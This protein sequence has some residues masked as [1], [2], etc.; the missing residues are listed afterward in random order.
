MADVCSINQNNV[1]LSSLEKFCGTDVAQFL[2][3]FSKAFVSNPQE[4]VLEPRDK[5]KTWYKKEFKKELDINNM[6]AVQVKNAIVKYYEYLVPTYKATEVQINHSRAAMFGYTSP[7]ARKKALAYVSMLIYKDYMNIER[8]EE[9]ITDNILGKLASEN[10]KYIRMKLAAML[11]NGD[12]ETYKAIWR[13]L[14]TNCGEYLDE[15]IALAKEDEPYDDATLNWTALYRELTSTYKENPTDKSEQSKVFDEIKNSKLITSLQLSRYDN[16]DDLEDAITNALNATEN[17]DHNDPDEADQEG[18]TDTTIRDYNLHHGELDDFKKHLTERIRRVLNTIPKLNSPVAK[19]NNESDKIQTNDQDELDLKIDPSIGFPEYHNATEIATLLYVYVDKD[20][21]EAMAQSVRIIAE[22]FPEYAGLSVLANQLES[23]RDL[24]YAFY[25]NFGKHII[26]KAQTVLN[27]GIVRYR[28]SNPNASRLDTLRAQYKNEFVSSCINVNYNDVKSDFDKLLFLNNRHKQVGVLAG[29]ENEVGRS[30]KV[31]RA[32]KALYDQLKLFYPSLSH[33]SLVN[34]VYNNP[35]V[36]IQEAINALYSDLKNAVDSAE[37]IQLAIKAKQDA[38]K[39]ATEH[40]ITQM[41]KIRTKKMKAEDATFKDVVALKKKDP[42]EAR[43]LKSPMAFAE[44][45]MKFTLIKANINSVNVHGNQSSDVLNSSL[46]TRLKAIFENPE[47]GKDS[48]LQLLADDYHLNDTVQYRMSNILIEQD[49]HPGIFRVVNGKYIPT[50]YANDLLQFTLFNGAINQDTET[51]V[52]Y[53]EMSKG[54]YIGTS[55]SNFFS[56]IDSSIDGQ[57]IKLGRYFL[58]IPSD[59]PK[60]FI[61]R[62]PRYLVNQEHPLFSTGN[63][64]EFDDFIDNVVKKITENNANVPQELL[65]A[66]E[67][68]TVDV[69]DDKEF[70]KH[71]SS[72]GETTVAIDD[73]LGVNRNG[74]EEGRKDANTIKLVKIQQ[75]VQKQIQDAVKDST[76]KEKDSKNARVAVIFRKKNN[77]GTYITYVLEGRYYNGKLY[78]TKF[79]NTFN[80]SGEKVNGEYQDLAKNLYDT[81]HRALEIDFIEKNKA[82][83]GDLSVT[84]KRVVNKDHQLFKQLKSV[85]KQ[86]L[87]DAVDAI[88]LMF[89]TQAAVDGNGQPIM[90]NGKQVLVITRDKKLRPILKEEWAKDTNGLS[91]IYH[92]SKKGEVLKENGKLAGRVFESDRF[93]VF[94]E[95]NNVIRNYGQEL[96]DT[97]LTYMTT[98]SNPSL[99]NLV[100]WVE[101]NGKFDLNLTDNQERA[102]E[103]KIEEFI[104]DFID[105]SY[106]RLKNKE[107]FLR[108]KT[109]NFDNVAD[110]M[111]NH[112]LMYVNSNELL[113][114]DTKYYEDVQTFLKRTKEYQASGNPYGITSIR[115]TLTTSPVDKIQIGPA[116]W[117]VELSDRFNAITFHTTRKFREQVLSSLE[118]A[119]TNKKLMGIHAMSEKD[120]RNLMRGND[121]KHGYTDA[122]VNDAQSYITFEEWIRRVAA[123]GELDKYTPLINRIM[124]GEELTPGDI[125][126]FVQV[127]KNIYYDLYYDPVTNRKIPRQIKNAEFVLVPQFIEGTELE[128]VYDFMR[129]N[130]IHQINTDE[131][132]K[133]ANGYIVDIFD[134]DGSLKQEIVDFNQVDSLERQKKEAGKNKDT[135]TKKVL[136]KQIKNA[137]KYKELI[138][139]AV[140]PYSYNYL[141]EQQ[142]V[143]QHMFAN[144]KFAIQIAKKIIDNIQRD[145]PLYATKQKYFDLMTANIKGSFINLMKD[146]NIPVDDNGN[147]ITDNPAAFENVDYEKFYEKL[148]VELGRLGLDDNALDYATLTGN[149]YNPSETVMPNYIGM[150]INK[151]ESIVQSVVTKAV[152]RQTLHGFHAA[153]ITN[154]G[155]VELASGKE[156]IKYDSSLKY[157]EEGYYNPTTNKYLTTEEYNKLSDK[158]GFEKATLPYVEV[159][160]PY[161]AFGIDKNS[162]HYK[163]MTDDEIIAEL[164]EK[165]L[166][167]FIGYRIP[168]EGKQ[169]IG[170][171]KLAKFIPDELGSTIV[172]PIE[173]VPQTGSDFDVDSVYGIMHKVTINNKGEVTKIKYLDKGDFDRY[174]W[175]DYIRKQGADKVDGVTKALYEETKSE[176]KQAGKSAVRA[177]RQKLQE[178]EQEAYKNLPGKY[179]FKDGK[180]VYMGPKG[181]VVQIHR[182]MDENYGKTPS[183]EKYMDQLANEIDL[184]ENHIKRDTFTQEQ[185]DGIDKYLEIVKLIYAGISQNTEEEAKIYQEARNSKFESTINEIKESQFKAYQEEAENEGLISYDE[186]I[187]KANA[188]PISY[189]TRAARDNEIVTCMIDIMGHPYSLEETLSR[190]NFDNIAGIPGVSSVDNLRSENE[191]KRRKNRSPFNILDEADF[192]E[193]AMQGFALK[194]FSVSRDTFCSVCNTV[195][196]TIDNVYAPIVAY[197]FSNL[198]DEEFTAKLKELHN[199]FDDEGQENVWNRG[200]VIAVRHNKI[201]WSNGNAISSKGERFS[202]DRNI[203]GKTITVYSSQTTAHIL[204]AMKSGPVPNVNKYTFGVYKTLVDVG[205]RYDTAIGFIMHPAVAVINEHYD[206]TNSI[207]ATDTNTKYIDLALN[208]YCDKLAKLESRLKFKKRATLDE[209]LA[210]I[211]KL[212]HTSYSTDYMANPLFA[213]DEE[214]I[215]LRIKDEKAYIEKAGGEIGMCLK[216]MEHVLHF[217]KLEKLTEN[218]NSVQQVTNPDKF[219]AK[220]SIFETERV[221][222]QI[223]DYVKSKWVYDG[224]NKIWVNRS[225]L[226]VDGRDILEAIYPDFVNVEKAY[227]DSFTDD[228]TNFV[229]S[230]TNVSRSKYPTLCSHLKYGSAT[231][232]IV[233]SMFFVTQTPQFKELINSLEAS[234]S[235][236]K[237]LDEKTYREARSYL[238]NSLYKYCRFLN[239]PLNYVKGKGFQFKEESRERNDQEVARVYGYSRTIDFFVPVE[240]KVTV[241]NEGREHVREISKKVVIEDVNNPTKKQI[242]M[243]ALLSPA[244]KIDFIKSRFRTIG[245]EDTIFNY[246]STRLYTTIDTRNTSAGAQTISFVESSA[247]IDYLRDLFFKAY[248][249]TNP[250]IALTA[251]DMIKYAFIVDGYMFTRNGISKLIPNSLLLNDGPFAGTNIIPEMNEKMSLINVYLDDTDI[252]NFIRANRNLRQINTRRVKK[253]KGEYEL[254]RRKEGMIFITP[255]DKELA[256]TYGVVDDNGLPNSYVRLKFEDRPVLYKIWTFDDGY[257][258]LTPLNDLEKNE[259]SNWSANSDNNVYPGKIGDYDYYASIIDEFKNSRNPDQKGFSVADF[260]RIIEKTNSNEFKGISYT[261]L[262]EKPTREFSVK[263]DTP[264][265]QTLINRA[266]EIVNDSNKPYRFFYTLGLDS[267][268]DKSAVLHIAIPIKH[269][270]RGNVSLDGARVF[271]IRPVYIDKL[272]KYFVKP[273]LDRSSLNEEE[274]D[275][276]DSLEKEMHVR[277]I[278]PKFAH[279]FKIEEKTTNLDNKEVK[280]IKF[281]TIGQKVAPI[282]DAGMAVVKGVNYIGTVTG[283]EEAAALSRNFKQQNIFAKA[284]V[285]ESKVEDIIIPA[286]KTLEKTVQNL[287]YKLKHFMPKEDG[288]NEYLAITDPEVIK[289]IKKDASWREKYLKAIMDPGAIESQFSIFRDLNVESESELLR[290]YLQKIKDSVKRLRDNTMVAEAQKNYV[291]DVLDK[292]SNRPDIKNGIVHVIDGYF[293]QSTLN[294]MFN[295]IQESPSALVQVTMKMIQDNLRATEIQTQRDLENFVKHVEDIKRRAAAAG[296]SINYDNIID[297]YGRFKRHYKQKLIDDRNKLQHNVDEKR[298][299]WIAVRDSKPNN[300]LS[301]ESIE[302]YLDYQRANLEYEEWKAKY[303]EQP[304]YNEHNNKAGI[305]DDGYYNTRNKLNRIMLDNKDSKYIFAVYNILRDKRARLMRRQLPDV[306][307]LEL[308]NEINELRDKIK[309]LQENQIFD[310]VTKTFI[311]KKNYGGAV[312]DAAEMVRRVWNDATASEILK[313]YVKNFSQN[314]FKYWK[315]DP[316]ASFDQQVKD[317]LA[318]VKKYE[319]PDEDGIPTVSQDKLAH[320]EDYQKA[321]RWLRRNARPIYVEEGDDSWIHEYA[322]AMAELHNTTEGIGVDYHIVYQNQKYRDENGD[323]DGIEISKDAELVDKIRKSQQITYNVFRENDFSDRTLMSLA[324][325]DDLIYTEAFWNELSNGKKSVKEEYKNTITAINNL[326]SPYYNERINAID[327]SKL[328]E[329]NTPEEV[330]NILTALDGLYTILDNLSKGTS[331]GKETAEFIEANCVTSINEARYSDDMTFS[332]TLPNNETANLFRKIITGHHKDDTP[333]NSYLYKSFGIKHADVFRQLASFKDKESQEYK[334]FVE[335]NKTIINMYGKYVDLNKTRARRIIKQY[336]YKT[337]TKYYKIAKDEALMEAQRIADAGGRSKEAVKRGKEYY[338]NWFFRNHVYNP[339]ERR[340]EPIAIWRKNAINNI[341]NSDISAE[342][343][344]GYDQQNRVVR[345]GYMTIG[346]A[347]KIAEVYKIPGARVGNYMTMQAKEF[348][349][350]YNED[351]NQVNKNYKEG[352]GHGENYKVGTSDEYD[353]PD[354][355]NEYEK[356]LAE[357]FQRIINALT[358]DEASQHYIQYGWL[359]SRMKREEN[360]TKFVG[361]ELKT[362]AGLSA[363]DNGRDDVTPVVDYAHDK[364]VPTPMLALVTKLKQQNKLKKPIREEFETEE[365]Y[366]EKKREWDAEEARIKA[367]D[368]EAHKMYHDRDYEGVMKE[369]ITRATRHNTIQHNKMNFYMAQ[370]LLSQYGAYRQRYGKEGSFKKDGAYSDAEQAEYMKQIDEDMLKQFTVTI[371]RFVNN[372]WKSPEGSLTRY[373][374]LLQAMTSAKFMILNH[375]GGIAN[376][377]YGEASI[378]SESKAAEFFEE[379]HSIKALGDYKN[380]IIDNFAHMYVDYSSTKEGAIIK[381]MNIVDYDEITGLTHITGDLAMISKKL[382]DFA[383]SAQTMGEHAMQNRVMF[384][385]MRS[386]RIFYNS[387]GTTDRHKEFGQPKYKFMTLKQYTEGKEEEA[388][389]EVL[390]PAQIEEYKKFKE[391]M[392]ADANKYKDF[393]WYRDDFVWAYARRLSW[394]KQSEFRKLKKEK[395]KKAR[396]E[397]EDDV[398]HPTILSQLK[399]GDNGKLAFIDGSLLAEMDKMVDGHENTSEEVLLGKPSDAI[400]FLGEFKGRVISVNKKIHG[401]YDKSGRAKVENNWYGSVL[402]QYHKHLPIGLSKRYRSK[403]YFNEER[404]A[405]EKGSYVSLLD[406]VSI[407]FKTNQ[408]KLALGDKEVEALKGV[409]NIIKSYLDFV[410]HMRTAIGVMPEYDKANIRR[411]LADFEAM[412]SALAACVALKMVASDDDRNRWWYNF[413]FYQTDRLASESAQY[414]PW[415]LPTELKKFYSNPIAG[416][417]EVDDITNTASAITQVI[418]GGMGLSDFDPVYD[419]GPNA[420]RYKMAV[421]IERNIP[422]WRGIRSAYIDINDNNKAYKAGKNVLGFFDTDILAE[423]GKRALK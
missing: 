126:E 330:Y 406:F 375:K 155:Y 107:D 334:D 239:N 140:Q 41:Y 307:D 95:E 281:S 10:I 161:S 378:H 196:P 12:E 81:L 43:H 188:D 94:D 61:L 212:Y 73:L 111:L 241:D 144:N 365:E 59:A 5:F 420:G 146:F 233:N 339:Y 390:T 352:Y 210:E 185:L 35:G 125:K 26:S 20:D 267:Y 175:Y 46:I 395:T 102:I 423:K 237:R 176:S 256:S 254:S 289:T 80:I 380:S 9:N 106:I 66:L 99:E 351:F 159:M 383:Y 265:G 229:S 60:T 58:R 177:Y 276:L 417:K 1:K 124:N 221:F 38:I 132:S 377:T 298:Q 141:Y 360:V 407:P 242:E 110:Y 37:S 2:E 11:A 148:K 208:D 151:L 130:D 280:K 278:S 403:G 87:I 19:A 7:L 109:L 150:M 405:R 323:L 421:Y 258:V 120:A 145:H 413:L 300:E 134:E 65:D 422:F 312:D 350:T 335:A 219:G 218:I 29:L 172:L 168:T 296:K 299:H 321:R 232:I 45:M 108:G 204:D 4:E 195:R 113:E 205:S 67:F 243:F 311:K 262:G 238:I 326:L 119:L 211:N 260:Q 349:T 332:S 369:F 224:V 271:T 22:T 363:Y 310:S 392:A 158:S 342:W 215:K 305:E 391:Q 92:T 139:K 75:H 55:W 236:N 338:K 398:A 118:K 56:D 235:N 162:E 216:D 142:K 240:R 223:S 259:N 322:W 347:R 156:N 24:R 389:L 16:L 193:D 266:T 362:L 48:P 361:K 6:S 153:Q 8:S 336:S 381:A 149:P 128:Q 114:G 419:S 33:L 261:V 316:K 220:Q 274:R 15:L 213:I 304:A 263:A 385:M 115:R 34:F 227:E 171:M 201:G 353:N 189:N 32:I 133:A 54:D 199:R 186:Y 372:E 327:W 357:Y 129:A 198:S 286:A 72:T 371:Q 367:E 329:Y 270:Y 98:T 315:Y 415:V 39:S 283:E 319:E 317:N 202:E 399:L 14:T 396:Q 366:L 76:D 190:S 191:T 62:A 63:Q 207:Y 174:T 49:G 23:D 318:I 308:E 100:T 18:E 225:V 170:L 234:F 324:P 246:L 414:M 382:N 401:A 28:V 348:L 269:A 248:T 103:A 340:F 197:D 40:N 275:I 255:I 88:R 244:Q 180:P 137:R 295:D 313:Q 93:V 31:D 160:L 394:A 384:A 314:E 84:R 69:T 388:L 52:L 411:V 368:L 309:E 163:N 85:F 70:L 192:Q 356:D 64:S 292:L 71:I 264:L 194:G 354:T 249:N 51:P 303:I 36:S 346:D 231:S 222:K 83:F 44:H 27:D 169:S 101:A 90:R 77:D 410:F 397:F 343:E 302:A 164:H 206:K 152:T 53:S 306:D 166:D 121:G 337:E 117:G 86:E 247:D 96:L 268:F 136:D 181:R 157:H 230:T 341:V 252:E 285:V 91:P 78:D 333:G 277:S 203:D 116:S 418:L 320:N 272:Y 325:V 187:E 386:H 105:N 253:A 179:F 250:L 364:Y 416:F 131:T 21:A 301:V 287:E 257:Y 30:A 217:A 79:S 182:R 13:N 183:R 294:A 25:T 374:S 122:K 135:E 345:D 279:M 178:I 89:K 328:F 400:R 251:A 167:V 184:L 123:R 358:E 97:V 147:L 138:T 404:G 154:I 143:P 200:K 112:H 104:N 68:R 82:E 387:D 214:D 284:E 228:I 47:R 74:N 412:F 376:I 370:Q 393:A 291:Y 408:T 282:V 359:P 288:S 50:E 409:Q 344:A 402:M 290:P 331:N 209:K 355:R 57:N 127:Q 165:G 373:M 297:E 273:S 173:W 42:I 17:N 3:Y 293:K 245:S 226:K 379:K